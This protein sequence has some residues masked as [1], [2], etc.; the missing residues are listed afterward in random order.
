MKTRR[1]FLAGPRQIELREISVSP[2]PGQLLVRVAVCGLCNWEQN[3]WKGLLGECPQTLGHEWGGTVVEVGKGVTSFEIG[4]KVTGLPDSLTGFSDYLVTAAET[5]VKLVPK[6]NPEEV[7]GEPLKCIVTVLRGV[8]PEAGDIGVVLGCGPMGLWCIQG[9]A[10]GL[11]GA[12]VSVDIAPDKLQLARRFG[13]THTVNSREDDVVARIKEISNGRMADFVIEGTGIPEI[14]NQAVMYL[15][16]GR[17]RL[18]VMSTHP[19]P[20]KD[21]DWRPVQDKGITVL[22]THPPY[23]ISEADDMRRAALLI[24]NGTF[25]MD[26]VISHRFPLERIQEAFETCEHK[27]ADY[28][29]GVVIP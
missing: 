10:G 16:E 13:A 2:G 23:S 20:C 21:F 6:V 25:K 19:R 28:I 14:L 3:H 9:M 11:P 7:L 22:G 8:L 4:D 1:A 27:P 29:K 12:L 5:C 17:G 24:N 18:A 26:G 15:K